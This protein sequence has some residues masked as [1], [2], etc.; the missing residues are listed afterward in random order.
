MSRNA[1]RRIAGIV[2]AL[3]AVSLAVAGCGS[4]S[5]ED[6]AATSAAPAASTSAAPS[7][8]AAPAAHSS[9]S[10][11]SSSASGSSAS[12][13]AGGSSGRAKPGEVKVRGADGSQVALTG[14][15]A[16]KYSSAT[17]AQRTA[18]GV[19]LTGDHNAG[20]R[21][22][23]VIFQQFKGGVITARN[24]SA[25][26]PA[27]ITWGLIRDAW[28]IERDATGKPAPNGKNGSAGPLGAVT[29]DETTSGTVKQTTFE[30]GKITF[31]PQTSTVE[32]T[33]NG[34]VV[35]AGL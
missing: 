23:G 34:K 8:S 6:V 7:S 16:A 28:N 19:A 15:I 20:T 18:L 21:D 30:H 5:S 3:A 27:Y 2:A 9:A 32:V 13:S 17:Q 26:T 11:A 4:T 35:P 10:A 1:D 24:S 31:N 29:S 12:A 14:P 33:V 22:S 25:G